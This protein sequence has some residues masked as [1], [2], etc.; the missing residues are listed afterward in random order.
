MLHL[1]K[2]EA[3]KTSRQEVVQRSVTMSRTAPKV[4][5]WL[6]LLAAKPSRASRRQ[7]T[8]YKSEHVRG[9]SGI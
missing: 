2:A 6:Y 9:C 3:R 7:E 8:L 5:D 1:G 4:V